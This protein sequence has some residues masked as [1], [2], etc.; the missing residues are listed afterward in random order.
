MVKN[1]NVTDWVAKAEVE[2]VDRE[3]AKKAIKAV[4]NVREIIRERLG[5]V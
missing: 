4:I 2:T 5:H 1:R 3:E